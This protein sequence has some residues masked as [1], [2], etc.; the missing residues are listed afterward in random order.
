VFEE[1]SKS[2]F[3]ITSTEFTAASSLHR[4]YLQ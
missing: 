4:R 2:N 3:W 1:K